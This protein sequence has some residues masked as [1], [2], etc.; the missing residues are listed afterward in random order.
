[1]AGVAFLLWHLIGD[2]DPRYRES[3]EESLVETSYLLSSLIEQQSKDGVIDTR[4]LPALFQSLYARRFEAD[5]YGFIKTRVEIR[6]LVTD[7]QG[8]VLFDSLG[9]HEGEDYSQ[10]RDVRL[11]LEGEYGARTS[12]DIDHDPMTS[13]MYVSSPIYARN[14][15]IGAVS[16]GKPVQSLGQFVEAARRKTLIIGI[17]SM[18][19]VLLLVLIL[20]IWLVRP[21]G[22]VTDYV[23]YVQSEQN[24]SPRRL[25][26][27][28]WD[29]LRT[30]FDEMRDA[31]AGRSYVAD[32]VQTLTHELKSPVSAIQGAAELLQEPMSETDRHRFVGNIQRESNRIR[33]LADRLLELSSLESRRGLVNISMVALKPLLLEAVE[34]ARATG[35][36]RNIKVSLSEIRDIKVEGDALLLQRAVGNLLDNAV[37]FSPEGGTV[38]LDMNCS[39]RSVSISVRDQGPGIPDYAAGKVFEKFY[40]L[41]RPHT[42]KKSTGLGL[43]FVRQIAKL[44][45]GKTSFHNCVDGPGAVATLTLPRH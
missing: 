40:S 21:F 1:M 41:E 44:H 3:A 18:T 24:R 31:L 39:W 16:V 8:E 34:T 37:D 23:R 15:I 42:G 7:R 2:I 43:A 25:A 29:V 14:E 13:V 32:Y 36:P 22:L 5:I 35:A 38:H 28:A 30:A 12:R 20:S 33:Q 27:H 17:A 6:T 4:S 45:R 26:R 19:A 11:A 10:W 9:L